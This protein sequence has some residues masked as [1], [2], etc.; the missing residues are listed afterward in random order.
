M[1]FRAR[2]QAFDIHTEEVDGQDLRAVHFT[3]QR[4]VEAV[5]Q[6]A[7]PAFL[8]CHTYRFRG[9]HVGDIS[10]AYYRTKEEEQEWATE[11]DPIQ[12]LADRLIAERLT[13][14]QV[15]DQIQAHVAA[16]ISAGLQFAQEAAYPQADEVDQHVYA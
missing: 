8:I 9:H 6:G 16:E 5:R 11:R 1:I 15:L 4:L 2:P 14:Q 12:M 3:A 7:G 10:R 13:E